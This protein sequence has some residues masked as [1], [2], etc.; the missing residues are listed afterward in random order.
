MDKV[1]QEIILRIKYAEKSLESNPQLKPEEKDRVKAITL[2]GIKE[3]IE[4]EVK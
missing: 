3:F 4:S 2:D 1:I